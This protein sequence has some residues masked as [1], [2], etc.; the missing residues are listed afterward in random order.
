MNMKKIFIISFVVMIGVFASLLFFQSEKGSEQIDNTN[1]PVSA[2][3]L[4]VTGQSELQTQPIPNQKEIDG[5]QPEIANS[6]L[7]QIENKDFI[8]LKG[9]TV[10]S[11][12]ALQIWGDKNK[13]G[14]ALLKYDASKGWVLVSMGGGAWGVASLVEFGVPKLIAEQLIAGRK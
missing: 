14:E 2:T 11:L 4:P 1:H 7:A 8:T 10:V 12:Y 9:T 5:T 3:S 13:G 6:V